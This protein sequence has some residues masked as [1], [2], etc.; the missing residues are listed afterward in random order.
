MKIIAITIENFKSIKEKISFDIKKVSGKK[1]FILLGINESGKSN[2]LEAVSLLESKNK[3]NYSAYCNN[4]MEEVKKEILITYELQIEDINFYRKYFVENGLNEELVNKISITSLCRKILI[5]PT[6]ERKDFFHIWIKEKEKDFEKYVLNKINVE[7]NG[8]TK[9]SNVIELK[10]E[11]NVHKDESGNISNVLNSEKLEAFIEGEFF[12]FFEKN[13]PKVIFWK[14]NEDKYLIDKRIDLKRF[15]QDENISIPLKNC[16]RI[17][18]VVDIEDKIN[19]IIGNPAKASSLKDL[20]N[21]KVTEHINKVWKEH[22]ISIKFEIDN[23]QLSF[24]IEEKDNTLPKYEVVQRSDGFKHFISILLNLSVENETNQLRNKIILLDEPEI[25]LHPSGEKYLRDELLKIAENNIVFFATHSIYMVDKTNLDRHIS[26][27]KEKCVTQI[28]PIE[29]DN[30]YKEEVLY[31]A[32]G[33]SVLEHIESNVL[34]FEGK[35]DR[36][37]FDL[38]KRKFKKEIKY[39][40]IS[41]ISADGCSEIIKYTKFFNKKLVN[42]YIVM[43]S[44][45]EGRVQKNKVLKESGYNKNNTFEINDILETKKDSTLE[46]LFNKKYIIEAVMESYKGLII[47]IEDSKPFMEQIK[48]KLQ[49]NKKNY[50]EKE[51]ENIKKAFFSRILGLKKEELYNEMYHKYFTKLKDKIN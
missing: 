20:L 10:T 3:V 40:N 46:D 48:K 25:H 24:L 4:E 38:Y 44:D 27:K 7:K 33:T 41:L 49:E 15:K 28:F 8:T 47:D 51:K 31:E 14:P 11:Q 1:C 29:K 30:P 17:A 23:M 18:G 34:I 21:Q 26:V 12:D 19:A 2:I 50:G 36:D 16:F 5:K 45:S 35:T 6:G 42:G 39:P 37:I 32:L 13:M 22:K 9:L 43:D